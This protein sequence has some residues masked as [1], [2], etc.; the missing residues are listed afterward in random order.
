MESETHRWYSDRIGRDVHVRVYGHFGQP[1]LVFPTSGGDESEYEGQGMFDVLGHHI[2]AGRAKFFCVNSVNN[3]SWYNKNIHPAD[4]AK[5]QVAYDS[6]IANEVLPFIEHH[7]N[8]KGIAITTTGASF[9]AYHAANTL[10]KHPTRCAAAWP[11][12]ASTTCAASWTAISTTTSTSTTP[13]TTW[14]T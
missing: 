12:P 6:S 5:F 10:F 14:R 11:S 7:C 2:Q 4:R 9:G 3:D 8:Q 1:I 13:S